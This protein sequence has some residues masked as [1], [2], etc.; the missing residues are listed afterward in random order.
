M[1]I[2]SVLTGLCI[3]GALCTAAPAQSTRYVD[4]HAPGPGDGSSANP[5]VSIQVAIDA[6]TTLN[7]DTILVRPGDYFETIDYHT[8]YLFVRSTGGP[9]LTTILPANVN[10]AYVVTIGDPT[11]ANPPSVLEGFTVRRAPPSMT[12]NGVKI[13]DN[14]QGRIVR[15]ILRGHFAAITYFYDGFVEECTITLNQYGMIGNNSLAIGYPDNT[16]CRGNISYDLAG[17]LFSTIQSH[18]SDIGTSQFGFCSPCV[19]NFNADPRFWDAA[20]GDFRLRPDSPCIN[21]GS[22]TYPLDPDGSRIDVGALT[23]D[24]FYA[25]GSNR[26]CFGDALVCPCGNGGSGQGGCNNAQSTGGV[27]LRIRNFTPDGAGA[28]T[29]EFLGERYPPGGQPLVVLI[30][31]TALESAAASFGDGI[32]C[33]S[34]TGLVRLGTVFASGGSSLSSNVHSAGAGTFHYQAKYRNLPA[35]FCDPLSTFNATNLVSVSW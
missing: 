29:A 8:K 11:M 5:Y 7:G 6:A 21:A 3:F 14:S 28:G 25:P 27:E 23:F 9:I 26:S 34:A 19:G 4:V 18:Y 1:R 17:N 2:Q 24:P 20:G 16:I 32:R 15:C 13:L 12:L 22:P 35:G 31:N 30:R 33:L 10:D